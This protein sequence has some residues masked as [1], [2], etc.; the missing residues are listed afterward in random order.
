MSG[1]GVLESFFGL[2]DRTWKKLEAEHDLSQK[3]GLGPA[4]FLEMAAASLGHAGKAQALSGA[5]VGGG[6]R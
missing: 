2:L 4:A 6:A 1:Q 3:L 5:C